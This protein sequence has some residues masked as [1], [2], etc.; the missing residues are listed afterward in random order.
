MKNDVLILGI[1]SS[2]DETAISVVKNGREVLS[3]VVFSQIDVHALF[4]GVVPEIASRSHA[5]QIDLVYREALAQ[6]KVDISQISAIAVTYGAGLVGAL[7]VG[8]SFAKALAYATGK[9]LIAVNHVKGHICANYLTNPDLNPPFLCLLT[10]GGHTSIV[11]VKTFCDIEVLC[12]TADDAIG[13]SF[14]KVARVLHQ[15]YPGGKFI[16][17]LAQQGKPI[18]PFKSVVMQNGNFS[19]SGLKTAVINLVHNAEQKGE[20]LNPCDVACSFNHVAVDGLIERL[21]QEIEKQQINTVAIAGGVAAN[22]YLRKKVEELSCVKVFMPE[23]KYCGDN[24]AM[25]ASQGYFQYLQGDF[26]NKNTLNA[27]PTLHL[28]AEYERK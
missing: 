4:G 11:K 2:C 8:V 14:D 24:G 10:S 19:Y 6:A 17:T 9:P 28:R 13:E 15:P 1:E 12:S 22:T 5:E 21:K 16:D 18:Y 26:A 23:L 20:K 25:I 3:N 27:D 7:L